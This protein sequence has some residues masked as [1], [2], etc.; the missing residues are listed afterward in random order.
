MKEAVMKDEKNLAVPLQTL[1]RRQVVAALAVGAFAGLTLQTKTALAATEEQI[2]HSQEAIHQETVFQASRKRVYE[3]LTDT[4]QFDKIIQLSPEMQAGKSFGT[5]P[6]AISREAGGAFSIF[7]G[8][9]IGRQI[10]LI[11]NERIVQA[12]RVVDWEPGVYSVARFELVEQGA[13][14]KLVFDHTGF[15]KGQA[16][17]LAEGWKSHYWNSLEKFLA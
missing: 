4:K 7:G 13:G 15:P 6:T 11:P 1:T 16:E 3:A 9:I 10:E 14:T 17:H 5:S 8:H 12:W 2:S